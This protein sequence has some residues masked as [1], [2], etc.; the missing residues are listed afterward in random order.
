MNA[1]TDII[2]KIADTQSAMRKIQTA[3][4]KEPERISLKYTY[5][6]LQR[7]H[8]ILEAKFIVFAGSD[9]LDVC[10]YR[11]FAEDN[12]NSNYPIFA[13]GSALRNFQKWFS[14]TYDALKT[15]PKR[16]SRLSA[17]IIAESSLNFAFTYPGSV[18]VA[19]TIPSER[20]LFEND[21]QRAMTK[22]T[23][24]LTAKGSDQV[25]Y[26][27]KQL[28]AASIRTLY[29]WVNDHVSANL[30]VDIQWIANNNSIAKI[31]TGI[32][33]LR[34]LKLAIEETSDMEENVFEARG[35]L[36][37]AD[38]QRHTFHMVFEEADE[39]RGK[40]SESIG[41]AYTVELPQ[42]YIATIKK[43]AFINYATA[44]E[45]VTYFIESLK[46]T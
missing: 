29:D 38:T 34:N 28:G 3:M 40:M 16:R 26:F 23:E 42:Q 39:V 25:H 46:R 19:M 44:E 41:D 12:N 14:T 8:E 18:G 45:I 2:T 37:G 10:S 24:M 9:Q 31:T 11:I 7:R 32:G 6:S 13:V 30:G 36:V 4:V 43:T 35:W 15:G 27:A 21:L 17:D 20:L 5:E 22:T 33:H 1:L